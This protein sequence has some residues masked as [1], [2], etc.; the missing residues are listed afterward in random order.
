MIIIKFIKPIMFDPVK[1]QTLLITILQ[2]IYSDVEMRTS[3]GFKGGTAAMMFYDL[4]RMSVDL[5]FD[6]LKE[7]EKD[8]VFEKV[9]RIIRPY[10]QIYDANEKRFTLFF[11]LSYEKGKQAVKIEISKRKGGNAFEFKNYL[12]ISM[13]VIKP[14]DAAA[15]KLAALI[16]RKRFA[17]RDVFDTWYYLKNNW[18]INEL[19]LTEKTGLSLK[20]ALKEAVKKLV[21]IKE[22][23]ILQ[24]LGELLDNKQKDWAKANLIKDTVFLLKLYLKNLPVAKSRELTYIKMV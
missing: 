9:N 10:G 17:T 6:L 2:K 20:Q 13:L 12:G 22:N 1:H 23:Q 19:I 4:P 8:L 3:L 16:T 21:I 11:L 15:G 18:P 7:E 5:D 14:A 24:G